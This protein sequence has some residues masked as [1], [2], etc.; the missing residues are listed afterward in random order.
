MT[1][2]K[3]KQASLIAL[4]GFSTLLHAAPQTI[5]V[6]RDPNC[7]CCTK[8][9]AYLKENGFTVNDHPEDNMSAVKEKLGVPEKLGSCHTGVINGK[10]VEGHVPVS[11]IRELM[12]RKDLIGVAA[13]GMPMGSPGME[14]GNR[15][16]AHQIIG[17]TASGEEQVVADYPAQ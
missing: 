9:M 8:W 1:L 4:L 10:F 2:S 7:G 12:A 6:H 14:S 15:R 3:I 16:S 17:L 13:P 11:E 5:D